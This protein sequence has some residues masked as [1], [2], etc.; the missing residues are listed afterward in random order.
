MEVARRRLVTQTRSTAAQPE[1]ASKYC[2]TF[3]RMKK[4]DHAEL[5][6]EEEDERTGESSVHYL[7]HFATDQEKFRVVYN[8][9][10]KI[11]GVSINDMLHRGLMFLESLVGILIRF[12]QHPVAI[13]ADIKN[14][15]FQIRL[16]PKDRNMLRFF[17]FTGKKSGEK[18]EAWRFTVM[19]YGLVCVPS[20]AGYCIK[21][22]AKKSYAGVFSCTLKRIQTDFYVD[23]FITSVETTEE[24][25]TVLSD[26]TELLSTTG[27]T[28][29]KYS[30]NRK[31]VLEK[32]SPESLAPCVKEI[33]ISKDGLPQQ[34]A[35]GISWNAESDRIELREKCV[36]A[37]PGETL[38]RRKALSCLNSYFDPL[39]LWCPFFV[40]LK[41]CYSK[42]V[43]CTIGWDDEVSDNLR[44]EW[45]ELVSEI[46]F[47]SSL[48]FSRHYSSLTGGAYELH[49]FSD[50]SNHAMGA[51]VYLRNVRG[52]LIE[53][54]L[55]LGKA[56]LFP[57][58]QISK[59]SI[60]RKELIALCMGADLLQQ[61]K[62]YLTLP[63]NRMCLWVDSMTVIKWCQCNSRQLTQ[64]VRNRV[65]KVL[66]ISEGKSSL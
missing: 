28:L 66:K 1:R 38:T 23:D 45:D 26:A 31:E 2:E 62:L 39:G 14:M 47:L 37:G 42:I 24:A 59:F 60:A 35:L 29:N 15:F 40:R 49:L 65:D 43:G 22:T 8:G 30:S 25:Y 3:E 32:F 4:E 17:P 19:P 48:S 6:E 18:Q 5:V 51:C 36:Y 21:Y 33:N 63:I 46:P 54:S 55:V 61:C 57:Q 53:N 58:T 41:L 9:A 16:H 44:A 11:N 12:R 64:F 10:L 56:R 34:R 13:T 27:F 20:I 52:N 7:T 50:A